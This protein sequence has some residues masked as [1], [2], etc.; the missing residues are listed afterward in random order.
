MDNDVLK[1]RAINPKAATSITKYTFVGNYPRKLINGVYLEVQVWLNPG[2]STPVIHISHINKVEKNNHIII[3][4]DSEKT[5]DKI[6]P[7]FLIK[8]ISK[9]IEG[10][11]PN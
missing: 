10:N 8:I 9:L 2:K 3:F 5:F 1:L 4:A 7:L 6:L 11:F